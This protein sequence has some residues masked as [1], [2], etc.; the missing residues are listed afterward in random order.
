MKERRVQRNRFLKPKTISLSR[1]NE[2]LG[3]Y[4]FEK[5]K[6]FWNNIIIE[7]DTLKFQT[8]RRNIVGEPIPIYP[9]KKDVFFDVDSELWFHFQRD[10]LGQIIGLD[11]RTHQFING[12]NQ[13]FNKI[14]K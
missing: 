6:V 12:L 13:R 14:V 9:Y 1:N 10:S 8:V 2:Y 4:L 7:N 11:K 3:D 5:S